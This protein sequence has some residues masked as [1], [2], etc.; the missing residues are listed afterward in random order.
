MYKQTL[1]SKRNEFDKMI[2]RYEVGLQI[3]E[4]AQQKVSVLQEQ[5]KNDEPI[6]EQLSKDLAIKSIELKKVLDVTNGTGVFL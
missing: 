3:I 4:N 1:K 6:L 2:K 5:I